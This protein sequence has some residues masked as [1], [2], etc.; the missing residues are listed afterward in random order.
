MTSHFLNFQ[1]H[2]EPE[3]YIQKF[4]LYWHLYYSNKGIRSDQFK[5]KKDVLL[6]YLH[7]ALPALGVFDHKVIEFNKGTINIWMKIC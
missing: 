4:L 7:V 6:D 3:W 1:V 2:F 5:T